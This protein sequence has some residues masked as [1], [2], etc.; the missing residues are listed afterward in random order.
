[1]DKPAKSWKFSAHDLAERKLWPEYMDAYEEMLS[2]TSTTW[3]PWFV[4]PADNEWFMRFTVAGIIVDTLKAL[5][6]RYPRIAGD[7]KKSLLVSRRELMAEDGP[8]RRKRR[9]S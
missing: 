9:G 5:K 2:A 6:L 3:A 8:T 7:G 4:I 1:L